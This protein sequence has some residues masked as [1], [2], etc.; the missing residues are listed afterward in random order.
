MRATTI[1][2]YYIGPA[3]SPEQFIAEHFFLYLAQG[4]LVGYDGHRKYT[5]KAGEY[6]IARKNNLARYSKQRS[7]GGFSKVV[8]V[9]D[10]AFLKEYQKK[11]KVEAG[12]SRLKDAFVLLRKSEL[13][14]NFVYSLAPYY[15]GEGKIDE[16]FSQVKREEA[17]DTIANQPA[18]AIN[19]WD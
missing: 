17:A 13:V 5:L 8:V 15:H 3:I 16:N 1:S 9:F 2:S 4:A 10:E 14:P 19:R 6:C 18:K 7:D 11:Y 12:T